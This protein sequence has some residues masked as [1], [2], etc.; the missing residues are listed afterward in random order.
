MARTSLRLVCFATLSFGWGHAAHARAQC[1]TVA[2]KG[3]ALDEALIALARQTGA[4]IATTESGTHHVRVKPV[5]GCLSVSQALSRLVRGSPYQAVAIGEKAYRVVKAPAQRP[6]VGQSPGAS[7]TAQE[8]PDIIVTGAKQP[9]ALLR[10]PGS[11]RVLTSDDFTSG[12]GRA[13]SLDDL[14]EMSPIMQKTD[15][16]VGRNKLFIRGISDSSFNG[17]TESTAT[18]YFGDVQLNYSGAEPGVHLADME[19]IEIL[20]GPQET[21]YGS[22]AISGI[23]RLV[24]HQVELDHISASVAGG[25]T[26]TNG[27]DPG[28]DSTVMLNLPIARDEIGL[29]VVGYKMR[30]GGYIDDTLRQLSNV[31]RTET[32]GGRATLRVEPGDG[33]SIDAGALVQQIDAADAGYAEAIVGPESRRAILPQPYGSGITLWRGVVRKTWDSGLEMVSATGLVETNGSDTFDA[34]RIFPQFG[35]TIY[36]VDTVGKL[37]THETRFSRTTRGVSWVVGVAL[38]FDS[39]AESRVIGMPANPV[40]IIGV[41]NRTRSASAFGQATVPL[42]SNFSITAGARATIAQ[43]QGEPTLTPTQEPSESGFLLHRIEPALAVSWLLSPRLAAYARFQTGYRTGGIAVARGLGRIAN[44]DSDAI[45]VGEVGLRRER[46]GKRGISFSTA[47]SVARWQDIQ[48]DLYSRFAQPYTSNIGDATILAVEAD[49]DWVPI[50][51]L[52]L[53]FATLWTNNRTSGALAGTSVVNNRHLPDTPPFSGN[54]T[55][56]YEVLRH[57]GHQITFGAAMRYVGRSVLGTGSFLDLSQGDYA[58][59]SLSAGWRWRNLETTLNL[60]NLT[61]ESASEFAMGNPLTFGFR[62]Q[63]VPMRPRSLRLGFGMHW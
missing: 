23:L 7:E 3:G 29:R 49:G 43:S 33:W 61:N 62:E 40:E 37:L 26:M 14:A 19:R 59:A 17:P 11:V 48:A 50:E 54:L 44:F 21:L 45:Y 53:A 56:E 1:Q 42:T 51:G 8:L 31:N 2:I 25:F 28:Y 35:P 41:T 9:V 22:G 36:Q 16:G 6:P 5:S 34:T 57:G 47:V 63:T 55:A 38:L 20:E 60:D 58:T 46:G 12:I 24:P 32:I 27:G 4:D 18:V 39:D 52:R 15:L 13:A 30:D 10:F